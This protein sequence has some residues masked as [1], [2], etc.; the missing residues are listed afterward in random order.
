MGYYS[1]V[2][3]VLTAAAEEGLEQ[4]RLAA[5]PEVQDALTVL[6]EDP[7]VQRLVHPTSGQILHFWD[8]CKWDDDDPDSQWLLCWLGDRP[9]TEFRYRR[10]GEDDGDADELG[11]L[12]DTFDLHVVRLLEFSAPDPPPSSP[13]PAQPAT[14]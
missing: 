11:L 10:V 2:V 5:A 13:L 14:P 3:L 1:Q 12:D 6:F 9:F 4:A 8:W 7:S